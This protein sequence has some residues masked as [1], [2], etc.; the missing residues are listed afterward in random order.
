VFLLFFFVLSGLK[1]PGSGK[2][3]TCF[4]ILKERFSTPSQHTP[5]PETTMVI[6]ATSSSEEF[7]GPNIRVN[8]PT[9]GPGAEART[10]EYVEKMGILFIPLLTQRETYVVCR[11]CKRSRVCHIP[12]DELP[13]YSPEELDKHLHPRVSIIVKV[14]AVASVLVFCAPFVGLI[15][16]G[17]ALLATYKTGGW[18]RVVSIIGI[19]LSALVHGYFLY[20][21]LTGV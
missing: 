2:E 6:P 7:R 21:I 17:I 18:P 19:V 9:C 8:C 16:G 20:E 5:V 15:F 10:Y 3:L 1:K 12:L 4:Q 14:L 11:S 13:S